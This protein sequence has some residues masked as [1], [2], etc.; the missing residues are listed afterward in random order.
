AAF[1]GVPNLSL[2]LRPQNRLPFFW[3]YNLHDRFRSLTLW[4]AQFGFRT[5]N[6]RWPPALKWFFEEV[7]PATFLKPAPTHFQRP[8]VAWLDIQTP[9]PTADRGWHHPNTLRRRQKVLFR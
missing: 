7:F 5:M 1:R 8:T 2:R 6:S 4:Q 3:L 9:G